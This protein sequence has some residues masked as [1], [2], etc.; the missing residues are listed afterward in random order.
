MNLAVADN[1]GVFGAATVM[2]G[3]V[4]GGKAVAFPAQGFNRL[5]QQAI[6]EGSVGAM[7]FDTASSAD[8]VI[9]RC[10]VL[11]YKRPGQLGVT[12][13]AGPVESFPDQWIGG[14]IGRVAVDT[15]D[16][17]GF[18]RMGGAEGEVVFGPPMTAG[19]KIIR[20]ICRKRPMRIIMDA[21][22]GEAGNSCVSMGVGGDHSRL[23]RAVMAAG[24]DFRLFIR[25]VLIEPGDIV[26]RRI[27][28][29][30]LPAIVAAGTADRQGRRVIRVSG[31][32]MSRSGQ[33]G[34]LVEVAVKA[35]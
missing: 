11:E 10:R 13:P 18:Q 6:M 9:L 28:H 27:Q 1:T 23:M 32:M 19:A 17:F 5:S 24:A 3:Q 16:I 30:S 29:M 8:R 14:G 7:A 31:D 20:V 12:V 4:S 2:G 21:V 33:G 34:L 25:R 22:A 26:L 35:S 15:S